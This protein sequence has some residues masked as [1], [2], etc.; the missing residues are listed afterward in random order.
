M[1]MI[2]A[3]LTP[4]LEVPFRVSV[5][6]FFE[7]IILKIV[8]WEQQGIQLGKHTIQITR[9]AA[10]AQPAVERHFRDLIKLYGK[11]HVVN[12]LGQ[13]EGSAELILSD[14]F[15]QHVRKLET[16]DF[17]KMANFDFH[18]AVKGSQ[19]ENLEV[20]VNQLRGSIKEFGYFLANT[21]T[22]Q[23]I[24]TQQGTFRVN[25]LDCLDR[26]VQA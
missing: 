22:K 24:S 17:V 4:L 12:L 5:S 3:T 19:Y 7:F 2:C 1:L 11:Q 6:R 16:G 9:S 13:K 10:A 26:L 18:A 25:C 23:T 8:F 15:N 14:A 21:K 20:L